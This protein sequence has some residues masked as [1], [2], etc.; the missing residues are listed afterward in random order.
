MRL[1]FQDLTRIAIDRGKEPA[2]GLEMVEP[3][4]T[5]DGFRIGI[6]LLHVGKHGCQF[7]L[8]FLNLGAIERTNAVVIS[9][10]EVNAHPAVRIGRITT[11]ASKLALTWRQAFWR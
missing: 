7:L 8:A 2:I 11:K 6:G 1:T 4:T 9:V 10:R 5:A 3:G